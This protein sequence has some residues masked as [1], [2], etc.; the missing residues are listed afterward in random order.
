MKKAIDK[1][2]ADIHPQQQLFVHTDYAKGLMKEQLMRL[3]Q[4][5]E[6]KITDKKD[7]VLKGHWAHCLANLDEGMGP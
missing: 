5:L 6:D 2:A 4:Q 1:E 3:Q 7:T